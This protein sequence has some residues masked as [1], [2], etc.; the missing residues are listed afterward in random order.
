MIIYTHS[1]KNLVLNPLSFAQIHF[2]LIS[3]FST[4]SFA[5]VGRVDTDGAAAPK[6]G[7]N[8]RH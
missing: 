3:S 5:S 2:Y 6:S 7:T 4:Y 8:K 1:L